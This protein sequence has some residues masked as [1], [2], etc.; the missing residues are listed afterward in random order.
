MQ[1][2]GAVWCGFA[3]AVNRKD[4]DTLWRPGI[5]GGVFLF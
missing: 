2:I 1:A 3:R 5:F 4:L